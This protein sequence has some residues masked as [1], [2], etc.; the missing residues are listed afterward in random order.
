MKNLRIRTFV[1]KGTNHLYP[2]K[3][4][5]FSHHQP[6]CNMHLVFI[7][8]SSHRCTEVSMVLQMFNVLLNSRWSMC[9]SFYCKS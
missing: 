1:V 8:S 2:P 4:K 3:V 5:V 7:G 6:I 9:L